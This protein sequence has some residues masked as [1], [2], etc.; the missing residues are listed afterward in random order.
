MLGSKAVQTIRQF[1]TTA[2]RRG[3]AYG[4]P[5]RVSLNGSM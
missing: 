4:G 3:H 1:S 5:G 2:A